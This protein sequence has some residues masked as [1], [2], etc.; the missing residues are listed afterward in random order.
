MSESFRI[1]LSSSPRLLQVIRAVVSQYGRLLDLGE[2]EIFRLKTAVDEACANAIRHS[3]GGDAGQRLILTFTLSEDRLEILLRDFGKKPDP[4]RLRPQ[5]ED[6]TTP[7]GLGLPL[8]LNVMD[9]VAYDLSLEKGCALR[10]VKYLRG[11]DGG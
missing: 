1:E 3:Y 9:E 5:K 10:M 11:R 2:G 4:E 8:I 6:P 7:G